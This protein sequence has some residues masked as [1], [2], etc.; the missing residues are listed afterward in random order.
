MDVTV[1]GRTQSGPAESLK[2]TFRNSSATPC[3][4]FSASSG[5]GTVPSW[6]RFGIVAMSYTRR[7]L[8]SCSVIDV[9]WSKKRQSVNVKWEVVVWR[10]LR[11]ARETGMDAGYCIEQRVKTICR[12]VS[13]V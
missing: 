6:M 10:R 8:A 11:D 13:G 1:W 2:D 4:I 9:V 12:P 5:N 3:R 7:T